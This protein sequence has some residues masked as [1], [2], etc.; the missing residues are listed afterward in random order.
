VSKRQAIGWGVL[1]NSSG[2]GQ[3]GGTGW[4][5]VLLDLV[6]HRTECSTTN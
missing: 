3:G 2:D 5:D 4:A 6:S 1:S